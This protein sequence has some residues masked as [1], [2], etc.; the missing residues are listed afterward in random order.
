MELNLKVFGQ[1]IKTECESLLNFLY[2]NYYEFKDVCFLD[3]FYYIPNEINSSLKFINCTFPSKFSIGS[4]FSQDESTSNID[5]SITFIRCKFYSDLS[6]KNCSLIDDIDFY[7]CNIIQLNIN[8]ESKLPKELNFWD[9]ST[10]NSVYISYCTIDSPLTMHIDKVNYFEMQ[11]VKNTSDIYLSFLSGVPIFIVSEI[12]NKGTFEIDNVANLANSTNRFE[13]IYSK[14]GDF[15]T[16]NCDF[17]SY[18]SF[19]FYNNDFSDT[20]SLNTKWSRKI[21]NDYYG[22]ETQKLLAKSDKISLT[23]FIKIRDL[24]ERSG[25]NEHQLFNRLY[26]D[27]VFKFSN[28]QDKF[29]LG[30]SKVISNHCSNWFLVLS[31]LFLLNILFFYLL[32]S[33]MTGGALHFSDYS[34]MINPLHLVSHYSF[35][36]NNTIVVDNTF[37]ILDIV[38]RAI[39]AT[40]IY[41]A[42]KVFRRFNS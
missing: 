2:D 4:D 18:S 33:S 17:T 1:N 22:S 28:K 19:I 35:F 14:L 41:H 10:I 38:L 9:N 21:N 16:D 29:L 8:Y 39:N 24:L 40:L 12:F 30:L 32:N 13:M 26:L 25:D 3:S 6:F 37:Y 5:K 15:T 34:L 36:G 23:Y 20:K 11:S 31:W 7:T 27:H 42:V